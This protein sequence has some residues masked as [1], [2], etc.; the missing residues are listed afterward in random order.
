MTLRARLNERVLMGALVLGAWLDV[1]PVLAQENM[2]TQATPPGTVFRDCPD[3]P[4]MVVLPSGTFRM[5]DL[6]GDGDPDEKPVRDI[7]IGRRFAV[8]VYEVSVEQYRAFVQATGR[9]HGPCWSLGDEGFGFQADRG[10]DNPGFDQTDVHPV[11]CVNW[12]DARAYARWLSE[13]TGADYR[14]LSEAEWEY[15]ARAGSEARYS[16]GDDPDHT[17]QCDHANGADQTLE[18]QFPGTTTSQ[19]PDGFVFTAPVG[20][21]TANAF[22]LFDMHGNAWEWVED[23]YGAYARAPVDGEPNRDWACSSYILKGSPVV[24]GGS[25]GNN[26]RNLRSANRDDSGFRDDRNNNI[27]FRLARTL[28]GRRPDGRG[29]PA[30]WAIV[31]WGKGR[32][33]RPGYPFPPYAARG[34]ARP[35]FWIPVSR[36][37]AC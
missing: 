16:W 35:K 37:A 21:F 22:G 6:S 30:R 20:S 9:R 33:K 19:C 12:N 10:W 14:L 28:P 24:R 29:Q 17:E 5:G 11:V 2:P 3:C 15:A 34:S 18:D 7:T 26:P 31:L 13:R 36:S 1:T 23:C 8:G 27:G 4:E 32:R 25:W